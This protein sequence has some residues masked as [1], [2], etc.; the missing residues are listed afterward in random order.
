MRIE[1][2][3]AIDAA[4]VRFVAEIGPGC[5]AKTIPVGPLEIDG[6]INLDFDRE[7][8]LVGIEILNA[9]RFLP[10]DALERR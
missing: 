9:S 10:D 6:E 2:D 3:P 5:V 1:Y 7:G 4:Y 8:R